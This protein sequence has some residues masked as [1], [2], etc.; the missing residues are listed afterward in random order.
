MPGVSTDRYRSVVVAEGARY[1][2]AGL[3]RYFERHRERLEFDLRVTT[4]GHVQ[5]GEHGILVG[6]LHD[7]I[8]TT[9]L[10]TVVAS[11]KPLDLSL[12][13]LARVLAI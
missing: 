8:A 9:P 5:R 7:E 2:A 3:A 6:L 12:L 10:A 13:N 11:Q 1:N 4:L